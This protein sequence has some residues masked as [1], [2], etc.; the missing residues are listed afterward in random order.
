M[1]AARPAS[2]A[3]TMLV[4]MRKA[5]TPMPPPMTTEPSFLPAIERTIGAATK[6][7]TNR[8]IARFSQS[9]PSLESLLLPPLLEG[10]GSASPSTS[11]MSRA[12][13]AFSPPAK[14]LLRKRGFISSSMMR[15]AARS[16][17]APSSALATSMR[18]LRSF[19]A[20]ITRMPSPTSLRPIFQALPTRLA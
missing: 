18:I 15:M 1:S 19:L 10:A 14:S 12:T 7:P 11:P 20:T 16:G 3:M 2:T 9:M 8:K 6:T 13:A 5:I 4:V 17:T